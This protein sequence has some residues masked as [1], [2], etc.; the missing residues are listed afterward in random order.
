MTLGDVIKNVNPQGP[1]VICYRTVVEVENF[2]SGA[3]EKIDFFAGICQYENGEL[4]SL[5]GDNY[6]LDDEIY[7]YGEGT[8]VTGEKMLT[9]WYES[10]RIENS[11]GAE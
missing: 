7:K 1:L 4:L 9:V 5:D 8:A 3:V 6:S 2:P 10:Q 11:G